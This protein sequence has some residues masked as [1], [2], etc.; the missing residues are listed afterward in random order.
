MTSIV[1]THELGFARRAADHVIFMDAGQ[2]A[3]RAPAADF[4]TGAVPDRVAR[5]LGHIN[6]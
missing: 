3:H 6:H 4:F 2:I 1:V 5:F